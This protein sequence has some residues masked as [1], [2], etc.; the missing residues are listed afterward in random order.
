MLLS[1]LPLSGCASLLPGG[2]EP[3]TRSQ[4]SAPTARTQVDLPPEQAAKVCLATAEELEKNGHEPE[5]IVQYEKARRYNPH[6]T[7]V[8]RRLAVLY[9]RQCDYARATTEYR[10]ALQAS[11]HDADLLNDMGYFCY[12]R[13]EWSEAEKYLRQA[14]AVSPGQMRAWVNLGMALAQQGHSR[15]SFEAFAKAV[16]PAQAHYNVG[17]ILAQQGKDQEA[18]EALRQALALEPDLK[19]A[20]LVLDR[21]D[22]T[23]AAAAK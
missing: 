8:S 2:M 12:E 7:Q 20:R 6:L 1:L 13:G 5:A 14:I 11:P 22:R 10:Q 17:M 9:D 16:S 3:V 21:L 19:K 23:T 18:R 4:V 15:E